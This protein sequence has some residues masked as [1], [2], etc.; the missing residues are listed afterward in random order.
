MDTI[1]VMW[2]HA[3]TLNELTASLS[4]SAK[5]ILMRSK[6]ESRIVILQ[7]QSFLQGHRLCKPE[8]MKRRPFDL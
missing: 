1:A 6:I 7:D 3:V 4:L 8:L 2:I 5:R